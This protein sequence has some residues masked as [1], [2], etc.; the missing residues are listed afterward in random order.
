MKKIII[1]SEEILSLAEKIQ[2][3]IK[4]PLT[5]N[6]VTGLLATVSPNVE[7]I[8]VEGTRFRPENKGSLWLRIPENRDVFF[9]DDVKEYNHLQKEFHGVIL[10]I[11][12]ARPEWWLSGWKRDF[13]SIHVPIQDTII[14]GYY[15]DETAP[16]VISYVLKIYLEL[17]INE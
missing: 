1:H 13:F 15:V 8:P 9:A 6:C 11:L 10:P 16:S 12:T 5:A 14:E 2:F 7:G 17:D 4:L 3:Q